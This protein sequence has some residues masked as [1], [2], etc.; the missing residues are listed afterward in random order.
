MIGFTLFWLI[1][2]YTQK[3]ESD[4]SRLS[5]TL[6]K[7]DENLEYL[8]P[9]DLFKDLEALLVVSIT[10]PREGWSCDLQGQPW[11]TGIPGA[12][13]IGHSS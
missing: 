12:D 1:L 6:C 10:V 11:D 3:K 9:V 8:Q 13:F 7:S 4:R 2:I 5:L